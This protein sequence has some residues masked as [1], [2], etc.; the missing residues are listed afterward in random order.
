MPLHIVESS[1]GKTRQGKTHKVNA[2]SGDVA[3]GV[4][5]IRKSKQ[6]ARLAHARVSDQEQLE[7]VIV[8]AVTS[9]FSMRCPSVG[10]R[11]GGG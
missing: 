11:A 2:N 8:S 10:R 3:L 6:Q 1:S 9:P 5:I 4:G 7:E